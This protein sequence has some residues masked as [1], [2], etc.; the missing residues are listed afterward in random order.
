MS[1]GCDDR[2]FWRIL[3]L[4]VLAALAVRVAYVGLAKRDEAI[5]GDQLFYNSE[6]DRLVD[7]DGFVEPLRVPVLIVTIASAV[8]YGQTRFRVPPEPT[9]VVLAAVAIA[10]VVAR[11]WPA[12][13]KQPARPA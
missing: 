6:S 12:R 3:F 10:A 9:L 2:R 11:D 13:R 4:I 7:G 8:T 5:R 1:G